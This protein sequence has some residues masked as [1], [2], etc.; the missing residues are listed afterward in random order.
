MREESL[1]STAKLIEIMFHVHMEM[2]WISS[3]LVIFVLSLFHRAHTNYDD[4]FSF[5]VTVILWLLHNIFQF[6]QPILY[7]EH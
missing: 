3:A 2:F 1:Y 6:I 5:V 7:G 4:L